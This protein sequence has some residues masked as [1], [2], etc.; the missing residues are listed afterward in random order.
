[1]RVLQTTRAQLNRD[2]AKR[3]RERRTSRKAEVHSKLKLLE[4]ERAGLLAMVV[5]ALSVLAV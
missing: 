1:M 2:S 4:A 3:S 5:L